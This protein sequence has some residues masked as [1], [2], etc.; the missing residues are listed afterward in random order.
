MIGGST[1]FIFSSRIGPTIARKAWDSLLLW[2]ATFQHAKR[3][4]GL[5]LREVVD[6][7]ASSPTAQFHSTQTCQEVAEVIGG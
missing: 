1:C 3:A 4:K 2:E 7:S 5:N 6:R